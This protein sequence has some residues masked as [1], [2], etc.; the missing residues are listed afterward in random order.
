MKRPSIYSESLKPA[1]GGGAYFNDYMNWRQIE[2]FADLVWKSPA[3]SIAA[4][5]MGSAT[6]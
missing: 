6:T 2:E 3:A 4:Q 1:G 5:L